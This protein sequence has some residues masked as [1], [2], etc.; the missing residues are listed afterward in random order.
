MNRTK[1]ATKDVKNEITTFVIKCCRG[2]K[3]KRGERK[4]DELRKKLMIAESEISQCEER[5]VKSKIGKIFV[6]EK[7]L[8]EYC[9]RIY[10]IDPYFYQKCKKK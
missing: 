9:V 10:E 4:I 2:E 6:N 8:E 5:I 1:K 7:I 3:K